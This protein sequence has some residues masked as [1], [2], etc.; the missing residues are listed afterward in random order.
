MAEALLREF[1]TKAGV[2]ADVVSMGT[3]GIQDRPAADHAVRALSML[4]VDLSQHRSRGLDRALL[5]RADA[6]LVMAE[7]HAHSVALRAP[8]ARDRIERIWLFSD[9]PD[10]LAEIDDPVGGEIH[11]F[12]SCRDELIECLRNWVAQRLGNDSSR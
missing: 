1:L 10:R 5:A 3:L 6:V 9:E 2:D 11:D 12:I 4:G 8:E 7:E